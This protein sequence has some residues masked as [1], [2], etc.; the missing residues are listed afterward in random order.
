LSVALI[1][2]RQMVRDRL[3]VPAHDSFFDGSIIDTNINLANFA[4]EGEYR[5]PWSERAD[6]V[7]IPTTGQLTVPDNWRSTRAL[8][9]EYA[10]LE[11]WPYYDLRWRYSEES[12]QPQHFSLINKTLHVRPI[13]SQEIPA[14]HI[15]YVQPDVLAQDTD[16]PALPN[17]HIGTLVAKAAQLCAIREDDRPSADSHLGEYLQGLERMRKDVKGTTRPGRT[18]VRAGSW[19]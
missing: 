15:Y 3:G 4:I 17:E 13:P 11:E 10:E 16:E 9:T 19:L 18:R 7:V 12:G 8:L 2:L 14:T 6:E 1:K 5:W